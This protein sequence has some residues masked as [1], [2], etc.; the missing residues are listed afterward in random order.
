L[1]LENENG[2]LR[3]LLEIKRTYRRNLTTLQEELKAKFER[4]VAEGK[5]RFKEQYLGEIVDVVFAEPAP[6]LVEPPK[7]EPAK[8]EPAKVEA[9]PD[10]RPRCPECDALVNVDDKFCSKCATPLKEEEAHDSETVVI[11]GRRF[12]RVR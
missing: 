7:P 6:V 11:A 10:D 8:P 5:R 1:T 12:R 2:E 9:P 3:Q 4:E